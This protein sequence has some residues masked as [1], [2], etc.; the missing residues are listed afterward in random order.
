MSGDVQ[1]TLQNGQRAGGATVDHGMNGNDVADW[2]TRGVVG[3]EDSATRAAVPHREHPLGIGHG[4]ISLLECIFHVDRDR[5]G[6][7]QQIG[8]ARAG[9][10]ADAGA[11]QVVVRVAERVD[12]ELATIARA[13]VDMAYAQGAPEH[14]VQLPLDRGWCRF[15]SIWHRIRFAQ[16]AGSANA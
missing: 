11:L 3:A 9:Y 1:E 10:E 2:T 15:A 6:D 14:G 7:Q 12:F 16:A 13:G 8:M 4:V 5:P